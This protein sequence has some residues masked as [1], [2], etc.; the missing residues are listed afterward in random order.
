MRR[1]WMVVAVLVV[2]ATLI[3]VML[4]AC[5]SKATNNTS[6]SPVSTST[7]VDTTTPAVGDVDLV[8]WSI[9]AEP[10]SMDVVYDADFDTG[11]ISANV[12]ERLLAPQPDFSV[13]PVLAKSVSNP[14]PLTW[15]YTIRDGVTFQDGSPLTAEDVAYSLKRNMDPDVGSYWGGAYVNVKSISVT[16]RMEVTVKLKQPDYLFN[17][18]MAT[19]AGGIGCKATIEKLGKSYGTPQGGVNYTGPYKIEDWAKGQSI[20]LVRN[21]NYWDREHMPR[22]Q[23]IKFVIISDPA[24]RISAMLA[25]QVDGSWYVPLQGMARLRTSDVGSLYFGRNTVG[26][27]AIVL[28][29]KGALKDVR[30]RQALSMA[31]DRE[32]IVKAVSQGAAEPNR[33]PAQPG[34]WGYAEDV[35]SPAYDA[36]QTTQLNIEEATRLVQEAGAPTEPIT[37]AVTPAQAEIPLVG[38][39][40]QA[41]GKKIGLNVKLR[42]LTGEQANAVYVDPKARRGLD[43]LLTNWGTD[44]ADPLQMYQYFRSDNF[45]NMC[46]YNNADVDKLVDEAAQ[47]AD[48]TARAKLVVQ[49]QQQIV[50]DMIWIPI[51]ALYNSLYM[52]KAITGSPVSDIQLHYPWAAD[53]GSAQ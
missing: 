45:Y 6:S 27:Q 14:D 52:N 4:V 42:S 35:F 8:T 28:N 34:T 29:L 11:Q 48:Q 12:C 16:E 40:M 39:Q 19:P 33:A 49:A 47:T 36:L 15:V 44:F 46:G 37:I 51:Y 24:G 5:G 3:S 20:T 13:K 26:L 23:R 43:I 22:A 30:I 21:D 32:G 25:G 53:I 38:L 1:S 10:S 41:A 31:I 50:N 18:Y 7:L 2:T 17:Q 9:A